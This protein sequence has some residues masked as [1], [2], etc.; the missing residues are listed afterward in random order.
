M[1][2]SPRIKRFWIFFCRLRFFRAYDFAFLRLNCFA[3][4]TF[5][6]SLV[7]TSLE[8]CANLPTVHGVL[9]TFWQNF[10]FPIL[11]DPAAQV[12]MLSY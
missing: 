7:K 1:E 10:C 4:P 2:L 9:Q 5:S 3:T 12:P 11:A 8:V 6:P